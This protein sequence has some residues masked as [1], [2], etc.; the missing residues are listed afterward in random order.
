VAVVP[1]PDSSDEPG[2]TPREHYFTEAPTTG[3]R[4]A[5]VRLTL[6]DVTLELTTDRG[7]FSPGRIDP[8]TKLL[9]MEVAVPLRGPVLDLG[10]GYGP[11]ACTVARR[12]PGAEV[13][14]VD[15]NRRAREL[16]ATNAAR[17]GL[18]VRVAAPD[19]VPGDQ[20]FATIVS[21][22]PIRIGKPALHDLLET[23]LA[24]LEPNGEAWLVVNRNLG[25]DS[26][27]AWL[28]AR[29]YGV[30][31]VRSRQGYRVLRVDASADARGVDLQA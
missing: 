15:V 17:A 5:S 9:L 19:E 27:A 7:V 10:C 24:R 14:A 25:A 8:G 6:P 28:L 3:S 22:P 20:R 1:R 12:N 31:R 26:L 13:W 23:W 29:G 16:C 30:D 11:I 2:V 21:N 18:E 4:P